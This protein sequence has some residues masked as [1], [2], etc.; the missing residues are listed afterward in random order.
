MFSSPVATAE[1]APSSS[2]AA[3]IIPGCN[4]HR[5]SVVIPKLRASHPLSMRDSV[6]LL[7]PPSSR[8]TELPVAFLERCTLSPAFSSTTPAKASP[9]FGA[10]SPARFNPCDYSWKA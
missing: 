8:R 9:A 5:T 7:V 4:P 10:T 1:P 6:L 3:S 2:P